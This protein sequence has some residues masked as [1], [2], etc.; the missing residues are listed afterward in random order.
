M[1]AH[2]GGVLEFTQERAKGRSWGTI[3]IYEADGHNRLERETEESEAEN[4]KR[5]VIV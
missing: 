5:K 3:C 1:Y 2:L 4:I